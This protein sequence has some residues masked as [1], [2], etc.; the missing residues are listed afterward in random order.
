VG[1]DEGELTRFVIEKPDITG[2][3]AGPPAILFLNP[4]AVSRH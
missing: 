2:F 4:E 3:L 1:I